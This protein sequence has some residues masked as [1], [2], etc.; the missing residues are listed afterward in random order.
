MLGLVVAVMAEF[1]LISVTQKKGLTSCAVPDVDW[2][3]EVGTILSTGTLP[4]V[5]LT[6]DNEFGDQIAELLPGE[7]DD[8]DEAMVDGLD[9]TNP[10]LPVLSP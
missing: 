1:D 10:E 6:N 8:W 2:A 5:G 4:F 7:S 3:N 9:R